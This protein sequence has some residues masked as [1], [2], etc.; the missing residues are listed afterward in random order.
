MRSAKPS[1]FLE[2]VETLPKIRLG[3]KQYV[4]LDDVLK[5]AKK[6][7]DEKQKSRRN[8]EKKCTISRAKMKVSE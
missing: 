4:R 8:E 7:I 5:I 3:T 1:S 6:G 2:Q